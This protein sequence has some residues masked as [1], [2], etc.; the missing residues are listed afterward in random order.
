MD[1]VGCQRTNWDTWHDW[2]PHLCLQ[3]YMF[4][5][6]LDVSNN[7]CINQFYFPII[8][9]DIGAVAYSVL[10]VLC[11]L[12]RDKHNL[13]RFGR[14]YAA[15]VGWCQEV[16]ISVQLDPWT[17]IA[18]AYWSS[19]WRHDLCWRCWKIKVNVKLSLHHH[20]HNFSFLKLTAE[21]RPP[22]KSLPWSTVCGLHPAVSCGFL[23]IVSSPS[24]W[25]SDS[26]FARFTIVHLII[27]SCKWDINWE[28]C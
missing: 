12:S 19:S 18:S 22:L 9:V 3:N 24:G 2:N 5:L 25:T 28:L 11:C 21:H 23:Y 4:W 26:M 17:F 20:W 16:R 6:R 14:W 13:R 27:N 7:Q 8:S 10:G 15:M 1:I